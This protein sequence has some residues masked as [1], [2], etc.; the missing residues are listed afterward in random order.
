MKDIN[1]DNSQIFK[2]SLDKLDH[3]INSILEKL[4]STSKPIDKAHLTVTAED[5]GREN[6]SILTPP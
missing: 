5:D 2:C 4:L 3:E 1:D 6:I